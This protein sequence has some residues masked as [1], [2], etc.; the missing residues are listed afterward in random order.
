MK[1]LGMAAAS[2]LLLTGVAAAKEFP[3]GSLL[4]CGA[5]QCRTVSDPHES[6]AFGEL[7][8]GDRPVTR[9]PTPRVGSPIYQLRFETRPAGAIVNATAIRVHGLNCGRFQRGKWYRLPRA[10]RGV[11]RG[12]E[13]KRLRASVPRSC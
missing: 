2:A 11:T 7:L 9:V 10:L 5:T 4:I 13:P 6:R 1:G 8:W 12:L 3:P